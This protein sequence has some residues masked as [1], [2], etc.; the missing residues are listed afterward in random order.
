MSAELLSLGT[1]GQTQLST[2][3]YESRNCAECTY[4]SCTGPHNC[5]PTQLSNRVNNIMKLREPS[6]QFSGRVWWQGRVEHGVRIVLLVTQAGPERDNI[7]SIGLNSL[8]ATSQGQSNGS[9]RKNMHTRYELLRDVFLFSR[10]TD[11]D[12]RGFGPHSK[13][14][15]SVLFWKTQ[16]LRILRE[17][18][19]LWVWSQNTSKVSKLR[20]DKCFKVG[21]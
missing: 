3:D 6:N 20:W 12:G 9:P 7:G 18:S 4:R 1:V 21:V 2:F 16:K 17:K 13:N 19:E 14:T 10:G 5:F 8:C 11:F 15:C